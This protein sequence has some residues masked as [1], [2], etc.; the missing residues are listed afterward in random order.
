MNAPLTVNRRTL[1]QT[2][3]YLAVSFALPSEIALG[4]DAK[5]QGPQLPSDLKKNPMLSNWVR[6]NADKTVTVLFGKVEL[7]QGRAR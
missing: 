4:Q 7:G 2:A 3:G 5:P 6:I 1:L